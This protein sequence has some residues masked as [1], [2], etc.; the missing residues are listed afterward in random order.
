M[1][2][3]IRKD[4]NMIYV[5][6]FLN[7]LFL[8]FTFNATEEKRKWDIVLAEAI[9]AFFGVFIV[10]AGILWIVGIYSEV[11][12]LIGTTL[13]DALIVF[14]S[15]LFS[16]KKTQFF[17]VNNSGFSYKWL[18]SRGLIVILCFISLGSYAVFG[19]GRNDGNALVQA[20]SQSNGNYS[21]DY[22]I[23][24]KNTIV[25]DSQYD[26]YF[27]NSLKNMDT[28]DFTGE[29]WTETVEREENGEIVYIDVLMGSYSNNPVYS[30]LLEL[31]MDIFG[32]TKGS[33]LNI[34]LLFSVLIFIDDILFRINCRWSLRTS[35]I[36][37]LGL[38]PLI[39]YANHTAI[40]ETVMMFSVIA[41]LYFIISKNNWLRLVSCL[42]VIALSM[43]NVSAFTVIPVI[44]IIY[45][46]KYLSDKQLV[47]L[48]ASII[49]S[50]GYGLSFLLLMFTAYSNT[51]IVYRQA[52]FFLKENQI[53][54]GVIIA[55][56]VSLLV[57]LILFIVRKIIF[58]EKT[59]I[60]FQKNGKLVFKILVLASAVAAIASTILCG[61]TE[62]K[63]Y[64]DVTMMTLPVIMALTGVFMIPVILVGMARM[65]YSV[66][67]DD[68]V[69]I[70]F[71]VYG[72]LLYSVICRP[73]VASYY[74][75][76][77]FLIVYIPIVILTAGIML[78][79]FK[80]DGWYI[81][82]LSSFILFSPYT[83]SLMSNAVDTRL[84]WNNVTSV[85]DMIQDSTD[86]TII[87][88]D[89]DLMKEYYHLTD[90][91]VDRLIYPFNEGIKGQMAKEVDILDKKVYY[92]TSN[93]SNDL[94]DKGRMIYR[95]D[96]E[97]TALVG[98]EVWSIISM[99][100]T[101]EHVEDSFINVIEYESFSDMLVPEDCDWGNLTFGRI[102]WQIRDIIIE[103]DV[104]KID[105]SLFRKDVILLYNEYDLC[106]SYH[107]EFEDSSLD[108]YDHK[109][110]NIGSGQYVNGFSQTIEIP[111]NNLE[112]DE[113][114]AIIDMVRDGVGWY[115]WE[116]DDCPRIYFSKTEND[117]N[118]EILE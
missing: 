115:S 85:I 77:R 75:E 104:A 65:K 30:S 60:F 38:V 31:G 82:A 57:P 44:L 56:S 20:F 68:A 80:Q 89:V 78:R 17:N 71:F 43:I 97:T 67:E 28:K 83:T 62:C 4:V 105:L 16:K 22:E 93:I 114:V 96:N 94:V 34:F 58:S 52:L 99:P 79:G 26:L 3:Q 18:V 66:K 91:Y 87:L 117:W 101:N 45:W 61:F 37:L 39:V 15:Y 64:N 42:F 103:D 5:I 102:F 63:N 1:F 7:V 23:D 11:N 118:Y 25:P 73:I 76:A 74:F 32:L 12:C 49:A 92:I 21:S 50:L 48:I 86:D 70:V 113:V 111:L 81:P 19:V 110:T 54:P 95:N 88:M 8:F 69:I 59:T 27:D 98:P 24:E 36:V 47:N 14:I 107:L 108:E 29:Y 53:V 40:A 10:I 90:S 13:V 116:Y 9:S 112:E 106:L 109:R 2:L 72:V 6:L 46:I 55:I 51:L 84:E 35:L 41:F 100:S 33:Y